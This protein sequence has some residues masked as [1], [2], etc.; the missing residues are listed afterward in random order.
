MEDKSEG[1]RIK[2]KCEITKR[3]MVKRN[4]FFLM[5]IPTWYQHH[6]NY[7]IKEKMGVD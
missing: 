1:I 5:V 3:V 2:R 6:V 7:V 4:K